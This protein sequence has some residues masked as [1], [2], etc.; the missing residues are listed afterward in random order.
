MKKEN[1]K[2]ALY[3]V[4][5]TITLFAIAQSM[6]ILN[7]PLGNEAKADRSPSNIQPYDGVV[8]TVN[9]T[10]R[11]YAIATTATD[12]YIRFINK[13]T[14]KI[15]NSTTGEWGDIPT[16]SW[17]DT[18]VEM[19]DE[20]TTSGAWVYVVPSDND[21]GKAWC[22]IVCYDRSVAAATPAH[23]DSKPAGASGTGKINSNGYIQ[24]FDKP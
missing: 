18:E 13:I 23:T 20:T 22:D 8:L 11:N 1:F 6:V 7:M 15:W 24:S 21:F 10:L 14:N 9:G 3:P 19:T 16:T 12:P 5:F 17:S 2:N 4:M